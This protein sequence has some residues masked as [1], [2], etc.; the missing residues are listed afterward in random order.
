M[1]E[2]LTVLSLNSGS[3]SLKFALHRLDEVGEVLLADGAIEGIGLQ[4]GKLWVRAGADRNEREEPARNHRAAAHLIFAELATHGRRAPDAVGHRVV[5]GGVGHSAA[6][7]ATP[8]LMETLHGLVPLA[9]L[10]LPNEIAVIEECARQFPN[11]PQVACFDTEF[12]RRMPEVAQH[13]PL[14]R[15]YWDTGVRRFGFHGIS[16]EYIVETLGRA[17]RGRV[18][19]AHLG[20][21]SSLAAVKDGSSVDTTMGF[22]PAGGLMMGTRT[23]DIDPGVIVHALRELRLDAEAID[24]LVNHESGLFGVSGTTSDM[25]TLLERRGADARASLAID[26]FCYQLVK[27]AGALA[28][29]LGGLDLLVFTGGIGEGA[30]PIRE[31]ICRGLG[32]LGVAIDDALNASHAETISSASSR[33]AVK[34]IP[35]REDLM[36]ARHTRRMI[37]ASSGSRRSQS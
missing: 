33:C 24:R 9:P 2:D 35:T 28:A 3:S 34:I 17:A 15:Q 1:A 20:N 36:I 31:Q 26:L 12:H 21:G 14:P 25:K 4:G 32:Y 22:T 5:H 13:Y 11:I 30:A 7:R 8:E 37:I 16:Y 6:A 10:H 27:H 19:I 23:G 18:I 29:V